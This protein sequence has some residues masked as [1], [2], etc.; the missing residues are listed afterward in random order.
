MRIEQKPIIDVLATPDVRFTVPVFQR[1]YSWTARQCEELWDDA[2][3]SGTTGEPHFAGMLLVTRDVQDWRG[4]GQLD[5]IDGQQR[6][7]T[8]TLLL[9]AL[10][11]HADRVPCA[12][13]PSAGEMA[14]R[15]LLADAGDGPSAKLALTGLDRDTL[16]A[17]VGAADP[18]E[19]AAQRLV[20]NYLLF[21]GKMEELGF[22]AVTLWRG[23]ALL[24][25]ALVELDAADGPQTVFES[26]NSKGM[27]LTTADRVRN[28]IVAS[29]SGDDQDRLFRD[30]WLPLEERATA[31]EPRTTLNDVLHAWLAGRYRSVRILDAGEVYGVLKACLRDEYAGSLDALL[32]DVGEYLD[33]FLSDADFRAEAQRAAEA[34]TSGKPEKSVSEFKL[35]GD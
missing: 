16:A 33:R 6:L 1:V 24:D 22:D 18:P 8:L 26:L 7:T 19:E 25:V 14:A 3:R 21:A 31:G 30:V 12:G 35:F 17:I 20:D 5:V 2:M 34:W 11:D 13:V 9:A 15:Y 28:L 29:T 32:A 23:L 27:A 10:C 4:L